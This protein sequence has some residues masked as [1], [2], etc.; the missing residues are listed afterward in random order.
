MRYIRQGICGAALIAA[1][2]G[3]AAQSSVTLYGTV[4]TFVQYLSN[5]GVHSYSMGSGGSSGSAF[6]LKGSED[7][8]SGLKAVFTLENGFNTNKGTLFADTTALFYRQT[9]VGLAHDQYGSLTFGRQYQ[10]S[11]YIVYPTDP[12][13][14][15]EILSPLSASVLAIDRNTL[16]TQ[17]EPGRSSNS[18]LY[19]SPNLRGLQ[20]YAM[21]AFAA[22]VTQPLPS[23]VGNLID[24]AAAYTNGTFYA[25][26]GYQYQHGGQETFPLVPGAATTFNL[27]ATE[28]FAAALAYRIGIVNLQANYAYARPKDAPANSLV[29]IAGFAHSVSNAEVG[30]TIQATAQ[31]S[32]AIAGIERNVRGA[33]DNTLGIQVGAD[34]NLSKRTSVYMRAGYLK[35]NG[36]A[37]MS[38]PGV[39]VTKPGTK[40]IL[41]LLGMTHRF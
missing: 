9:W 3:A 2:S 21:Y 4:D 29:A 27:M 24:V 18:I 25:G 12:F 31:D 41:G 15:N 35:N 10:P 22:T 20:V 40:Q 7:L 26:L 19:K 38:W 32:I 13:R 34:H 5:G 37:T 1:A 28:H 8:G 11:F 33:H 6:G 23:N 39:A 16:A 36:S 30:A 14:A 17:Y